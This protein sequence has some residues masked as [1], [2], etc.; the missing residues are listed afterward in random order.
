MSSFV[1][2]LGVP[3]YVQKLYLPQNSTS[4]CIWTCIHKYYDSHDLSFTWSQL[5]VS[6]LFFS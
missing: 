2:A 5:L 4:N 6:Q 3:Y 1:V